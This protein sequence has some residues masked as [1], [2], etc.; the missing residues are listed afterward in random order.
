[1]L[2]T[3][4]GSTSALTVKH[5]TGT[6]I[7]ALHFHVDGKAYENCAASPFDFKVFKRIC[8]WILLS[9]HRNAQVGVYDVTSPPS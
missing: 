7:S 4:L 6:R 9:Y 5:E 1:M 3:N 8:R 2:N